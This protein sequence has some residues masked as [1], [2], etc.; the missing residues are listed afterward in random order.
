MD[1]AYP[2][3]QCRS[4]ISFDSSELSRRRSASSGHDRPPQFDGI[5]LF[6]IGSLR[7]EFVFGTPQL[8]IRVARARA[9]KW[10]STCVP[11]HPGT[12]FASNPPLPRAKPSAGTLF[13]ALDYSECALRVD[14]QL[15]AVYV[16]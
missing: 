8:L 15:N 9:A 5:D 14:S 4:D 12:A 3:P 16:E 13:L 7:D 11:G 2:Q 6:K 1:D 10:P